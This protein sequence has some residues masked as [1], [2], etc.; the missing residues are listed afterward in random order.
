MSKTRYAGIIKTQTKMA[1]KTSAKQRISKNN[2]IITKINQNVLFVN[3]LALLQ[4]YSVLL[5]RLSKH[6]QLSMHPKTQITPAM[7]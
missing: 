6:L 7:R 3:S 5:R 2:G 4:Q 1:D